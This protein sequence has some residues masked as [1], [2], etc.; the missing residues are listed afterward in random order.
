MDGK[1]KILPCIPSDKKKKKDFYTQHWLILII[2][3]HLTFHCTDI[4]VLSEKDVITRFFSKKFY[5][6]NAN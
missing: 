2:V 4:T 6:C 1:W 3:Q 5:K